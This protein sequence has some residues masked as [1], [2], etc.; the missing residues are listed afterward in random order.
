MLVHDVLPS[1]SVYGPGKRWVLWVQGCTLACEGCWNVETW[2][3]RRGQ[4]RTVSS[5]VED[6]KANM[7][8]LEGIT[9]LGG[10]PLQQPDAVLSLMQQAKELGL[11]VMLYTGYE[12]HEYT[13]VMQAC[14]DAS[15]LLIGGR[16]VAEQRDPSLRWRGSTN[17]SF[18][19]PTG[20]Y[21]PSSFEDFEEVEIIIDH[22]TGQIT[23]TGY[24]DEE[25]H[26]LLEKLQHG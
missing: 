16:Y 23:M 24:P 18:I 11:T 14:H 4:E 17:Q 21:D 9:V 10:E 6:I 22:D 1:S 3:R 26:A 19:S 8:G 20:R 13:P 2:S 5:L 12:P 7:E 15:D 25:L